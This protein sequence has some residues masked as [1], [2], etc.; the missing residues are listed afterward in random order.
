MGTSNHHHSDSL[1]FVSTVLVFA[2]AYHLKC[3]ILI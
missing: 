3:E 2:R 1:T